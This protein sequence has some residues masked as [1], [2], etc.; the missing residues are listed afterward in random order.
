MLVYVSTFEY[1]YIRQFSGVKVTR[2]FTE[3]KDY[4]KLFMLVF[5][6]QESLKNGTALDAEFLHGHTDRV[7]AIYY[8]N[9]LLA[10]GEL[11]LQISLPNLA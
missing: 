8:N 10:T 9:G 2:E 11:Y 7:M 5:A 6:R 1:M 4:K 3:A